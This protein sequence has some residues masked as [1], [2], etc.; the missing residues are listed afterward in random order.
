VV[1]GLSGSDRFSGVGIS[2]SS[3]CSS[4]GLTLY[5]GPPKLKLLERESM[6]AHASHRVRMRDLFVFVAVLFCGLPRP[7]TALAQQK[8]PD[9]ST[10][11]LVAEPATRTS[12]SADMR[13]RTDRWVP[14]DIDRVIPQVTAGA[15]CSLFD[16]LSAA[17]KR[18]EEL[19]QN[20]DKFTARENVE[21]QNVGSSGELGTPEIRRFN[22]LVSITRAA[23][24]NMN[25]E[26]YRDGGLGQFPDHV[27]TL[28]TPALVLIF[29]PHHLTNFDMTCEG[30]GQWRGRPAWQVR[31]EE[32]NSNNSI[33]T[34]VVAGHTFNLR[35][36]GRAWILADS[37][38]VARLETDLA[39]EIPQIQMRLQ[40]QNIEYRPVPLPESRHEIWLPSSTELYMDFRGHRFYRQ[41]TFTDL[42]FFSVNVQQT[43]GDPKLSERPTPAH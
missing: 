13:T 20:V 11:T 16:V 39:D 21:H 9:P 12:S 25:V 27:A 10:Q 28:G 5:S 15:T 33:S 17:G 8:P 35:L 41:H 37:Y 22:Y 3:N 42:Q 4:I 26:E 29:H 1:N 23:N 7:N 40:H 19:V 34:M 6:F 30:L 18:I 36:R 32:R 38:Q 2:A 31:F 43:I 14:P 24:G